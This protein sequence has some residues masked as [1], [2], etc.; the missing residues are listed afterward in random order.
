MIL[1]H[2]LKSRFV[3]FSVLFLLNFSG[4]AQSDADSVTIG[5]YIFQD[6]CKACHTVGQGK[7][8]GP[9]LQGILDRRPEDEIIRYVQNPADFGNTQME[10]KP[11]SAAQIKDIITYINSYVPEVSLAK[12]EESDA[13][14]D[15]ETDINL[16]LSITLIVLLV[17]V[18]MLI[19]V[20]NSLKESLSQSSESVFQTI[21]NFLN[22]NINK[23]VIGFIL[24]IVCL[25]F[26][27]NAMMGIGVV[28]EYQ[29][30]QP[31]QFSHKI[32]AGDNKIDCNYCHSSARN[33]KTAGVPSANVCMNCHS[34]ITSGKTT[35]EKEIQKIYDAIGYD[36][37]TKTYIED[38]QQKPIEWIRVHQLPDLSYFNHSQHVAVAGLECQQCHGNMQEKTL[39]QVA[40][41]KE[42]NDIKFNK[43]DE[44]EFEHPTLTMGW[45]ID[46]HRQ[47][48]VD[49]ENNDYYIQ[50][51]ENMK[52]KH[53]DKKF[54]VD[55]IGGLECGKCHY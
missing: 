41:Y 55:M 8:V 25:R 35:G 51:H 30:D 14:Q 11:Y 43:N 47:K 23:F 45:C 42:L 38:Y 31:I 2:N 1:I 48:E 40:T 27:F 21:K 32:H 54:T 3:I 28:E 37:E 52:E 18:F 6:D 4:I 24:F 22:V 34:M 50:M 29:P 36:S 12:L 53:G 26:I 17:L 19:S 39:G 15:V 49:M 16:V 10:P 33:S 20:K 13:V 46:C 9:D 7:L 44:I 5:E